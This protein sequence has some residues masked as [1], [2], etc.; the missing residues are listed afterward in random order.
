MSKKRI[1]FDREL[2]KMCFATPATEAVPD[3]QL[4]E[5]QTRIPPTRLR[6]PRK[7]PNAIRKSVE[8]KM[9]KRI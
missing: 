9:K 1:A 7:A 6:K 4:Q 2:I 3:S 8:V 5:T